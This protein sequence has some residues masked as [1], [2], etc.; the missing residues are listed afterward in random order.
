VLLA[1]GRV[2]LVAGLA[3]CVNGSRL[4]LG[5]RRGERGR[6]IGASRDAQ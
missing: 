5:G 1:F 2:V 6:W 3:F 4:R